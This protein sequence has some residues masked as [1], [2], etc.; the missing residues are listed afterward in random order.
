MIIANRDER[1]MSNPSLRVSRRSTRVPLELVISV[2]SLNPSLTCDGETIVVNRHGALIISGVP[3]R[4]ETR[5][6]IHIVA[7][8]KR[9]KATV[10]YVDPERNRVCGIS[11]DEPENVW[12]LSLP[13]DDWHEEMHES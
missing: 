4:L 2:Q 5:I 7:T 12:G 6:E 3:L 8:G 10:V 11:L 1:L 9:A 13:P